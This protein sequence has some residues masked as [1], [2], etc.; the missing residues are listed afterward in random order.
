MMD[1]IRVKLSSRFMRNIVAKLIA[2]SI[3]K[4]YGYKI[5]IQLKDLDVWAMDGDTTIKLNA[6]VRMNSNEFNKIMKD[7]DAME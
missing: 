5:D 2:R 1:E 6:E 3:K 7:I 4:K